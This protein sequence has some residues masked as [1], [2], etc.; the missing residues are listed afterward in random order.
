MTTS[1]ISLAV[2]PGLPRLAV[3]TGNMRANNLL[4]TDVNAFRGLNFF[5]HFGQYLAFINPDFYA[6]ATISGQ[7]F[8]LA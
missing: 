8:R 1:L 5:F 7:G 6:D 2:L 4:F 3:P